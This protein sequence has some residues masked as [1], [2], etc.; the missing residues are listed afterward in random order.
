MDIIAYER[1]KKVK[2]LL[3]DW[4]IDVKKQLPPGTVPKLMENL[5]GCKRHDINNS[6]Q[7]IRRS[8]I[9]KEAIKIMNSQSHNVDIPEPTTTFRKSYQSI[10]PDIQKKAMDIIQSFLGQRLPKGTIDKFSSQ[11]GISIHHARYLFKR[12][13][14]QMGILIKKQ[15]ETL[16]KE[17]GNKLVTMVRSLD[18]IR[19]LPNQN[20][21]AS[22]TII[23]ALQN[24]LPPGGS[25]LFIGTPTPF[26][27]SDNTKNN[28]LLTD[29][30]EVAIALNMTTSP[31]IK[32]TIVIGNLITPDR[33]QIKGQMWLN[34]NS[35][36]DWPIIVAP[37]DRNAYLRYIVRMVEQHSLTKVVLM[38]SGIW[39]CCKK[40][41]KKYGHDF[42]FKSPSEYLI[43]VYPNLHILAMVMVNGNQFKILHLHNGKVKTL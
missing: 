17:K 15:D 25:G 33:A 6:I 13:R 39:E 3:T 36:N 21:Y 23:N 19:K 41:R 14:K 20:R 35:T 8:A 28:C 37:V 24:E 29:E 27:V 10:D 32:P 18:V 43:S 5:P 30:L 31:S 2:T 12:T 26:A 42:N 9:A 38:T 1:R 7:I 22:S 11:Y 34:N 16:K 40:S 4:N